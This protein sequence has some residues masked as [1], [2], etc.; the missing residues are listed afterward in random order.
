MKVLVIGSGGREHALV[1]KLAQSPKVTQVFAA[2]GNP[3]TAEIGTNV[4]ISVDDLEG[5]AKFASENGIDLTVVGPEAPLVAGIVDL[6]RQKGLPVFGPEKAA[7]QLEGSKDFAKQFMRE[8][9]IPTARSMTF[10]N[11]EDARSYVEAEGVPIVIKADGLAAGKGVTVAHDRTTAMTALDDCFENQIFGEAGSRVVIE[12][13]MVGEEASVLA[14]CDGKTFVSLPSSQDHK[15]AFD[16]DEGPNTGGMGAYSPAPVMTPE[17]TR[18]VDEKILTPAIRGMQE[19]GTPYIGIL[20]AG[21]MI[22]DEGPK[23]VEFNCRM[24][25]PETQAVLPVLESDLCELLLLAS[26]GRLDEHPG[27]EVSPNPAVCVVLASGGYPGSYEK[28]KEIH[29]L[30]SLH[31]AP[32]T[33]A[34]HA[35]TKEQEGKIVTAGGRVLGITGRGE[36]V[37]AAIEGAYKGVSKISFEGMFFRKDIG[38]KALDR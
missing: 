1:W 18:I 7:A 24:G 16:N 11:L 3:G 8:F 6:F 25:D 35:G 29:G 20:Y 23:V 21:L 28:G 38:K 32:D 30:E 2:P 9:D 34:F 12:E 22:T 17:I 15:P 33:T 19:R 14:I 13:C 26:E 5:L 4:S 27:L 10:D 31:G 36:T 37:A